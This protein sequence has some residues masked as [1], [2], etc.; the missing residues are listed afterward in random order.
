[1]GISETEYQAYKI[2]KHHK[3]NSWEE[4]PFEKGPIFEPKS[5]EN[6]YIKFKIPQPSFFWPRNRETGYKIQYE[7]T[8]AGKRTVSDSSDIDVNATDQSHSDEIRFIPF[9]EIKECIAWFERYKNAPLSVQGIMKRK[10]I[11][12]KEAKETEK[13]MNLAIAIQEKKEK[14]NLF[15][16]LFLIFFFQNMP[17]VFTIKTKPK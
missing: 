5:Y 1:M 7:Q 9:H 15:P 16:F 4:F 14:V 12:D 2:Y 8:V 17:M 11:K 13:K 3:D 6:R 10:L